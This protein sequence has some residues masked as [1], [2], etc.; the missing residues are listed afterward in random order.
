VARDC[1]SIDGARAPDGSLNMGTSFDCFDERS[2]GDDPAAS[3]E[4][5]RNRQRL[6]QAMEKRGF[7]PYAKEWWHFTLAHEPF[8]ETAFDFEIQP[9]PR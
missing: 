1:R 8:P 7:V 2:H 5:R 3:P 6:R 4:A 9:R